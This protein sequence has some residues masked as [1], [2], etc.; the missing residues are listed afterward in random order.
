MASIT[1]CS[2]ERIGRDNLAICGEREGWR[3][4][5]RE[6]GKRKGKRNEGGR[7]GG[8]REDGEREREREREKEGGGK[9]GGREREGEK[10]GS[11]CMLNLYSVYLYVVSMETT[12]HKQI[13]TTIGRSNWKHCEKEC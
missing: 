10:G 3:K 7:E 11:L 5:W 6:K 4:R 9:E 13:L 12:Y 2:S 1:A 8:W